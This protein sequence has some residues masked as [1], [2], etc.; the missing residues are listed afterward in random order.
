[1]FSVEM[2]AGLASVY[3]GFV[4]VVDCFRYIRNNEITPIR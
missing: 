4:F 2:R 1:M 3:A